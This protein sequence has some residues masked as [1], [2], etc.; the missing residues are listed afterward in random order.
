MKNDMRNWLILTQAWVNF[1]DW[2]KK[3]QSSC[4]VKNDLWFQK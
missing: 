1:N 3:I 4:A 2:A